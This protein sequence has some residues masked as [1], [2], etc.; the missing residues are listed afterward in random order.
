[1]IIKTNHSECRIK[2]RGIPNFVLDIIEECGKL[3]HAPGGVDKISLGRKEV[4]D[5]RHRLK[6]VVQVLDKARDITMIVD[7]GTL[8]TAYKAKR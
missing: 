3:E 8:I 6:R 2:Q 5:L 1:M 7:G 4:S